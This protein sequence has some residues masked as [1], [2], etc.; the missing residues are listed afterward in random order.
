M[1]FI[2]MNATGHCTIRCDDMELAG[3]VIQ[4]IA[5]FFGVHHLA[6]TA[7]FPHEIE[8]L[9]AL[10]EKTNQLYS[11]RDQLSAQMA[12]RSNLVKALLVRAEDSRLISHW[13]SMKKYYTQ[14]YSVNQELVGE[15]RVRCNNHDELLRGLKL[16]NQLILRAARLRVGKPSTDLITACRQAIKTDSSHQLAKL[17]QFGAG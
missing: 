15:Y 12:D 1:L 17:I 3:N 6:S 13:S 10:I 8:T 9:N 7:H 5:D 11:L 14:L 4:A 2:D 16:I